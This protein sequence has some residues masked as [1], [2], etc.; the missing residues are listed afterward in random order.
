MLREFVAAKAEGFKLVEKLFWG[1]F[2]ISKIY[3]FP[4]QRE[5]ANCY[6]ICNRF[7]LAEINL[8][9]NKAMIEEQ[10]MWV[11]VH[12]SQAKKKNQNSF[13]F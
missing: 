7:T 10:K 3:K 9:A 2:R 12:D 1:L 5:H 4:A 11:R 13:D 6:C 8:S